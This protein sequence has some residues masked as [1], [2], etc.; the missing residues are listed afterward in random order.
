MYRITG[1]TSFYKDLPVR[2]YQW[3]DLSVEFIVANDLK[4]I[5][6][7]LIGDEKSLHMQAAI[8]LSVR[9]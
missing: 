9:Y 5:W 8:G 1:W 7:V 2:Q 3:Y 6:Y 4:I